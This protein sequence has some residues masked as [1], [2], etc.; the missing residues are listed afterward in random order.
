MRL[1]QQKPLI[2][3]ASPVLW[4]YEALWTTSSASA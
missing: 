2:V 1:S 4:W 3:E